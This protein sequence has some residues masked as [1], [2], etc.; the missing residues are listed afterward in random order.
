MTLLDSRMEDIVPTSTSKIVLSWKDVVWMPLKSRYIKV[1]QTIFCTHNST[2]NEDK[3]TQSIAEDGIKHGII[4]E[5]TEGRS[6]CLQR[7]DVGEMPQ[8]RR[9][10]GSGLKQGSWT[11][12]MSW[13]GARLSS[14]WLC[15][16]NFTAIHIVPA[17]LW[18]EPASRLASLHE[19][20]ASAWAWW[21]TNWPRAPRNSLFS[22]LEESENSCE[23]P[24]WPQV[25]M[26]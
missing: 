11:N 6:T 4:K 26:M 23:S 2:Q 15:P 24:V 1:H 8:A 18:M 16:S 9:R 22:S 3:R 14:I 25:N 13:T 5:E 20:F 12:S 7:V 17:F 10:N 19:A 21:L